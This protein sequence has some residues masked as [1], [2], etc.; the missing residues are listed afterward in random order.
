MIRKENYK[1]AVK[2]INAKNE[3][4]KF[5]K[6]ETSISQKLDNKNII[7]IYEVKEVCENIFIFMEIAEGGNLHDFIMVKKLLL[8]KKKTILE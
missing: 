3:N 1:R 4:N 2:I 5:I 8:S 6:R 7:K